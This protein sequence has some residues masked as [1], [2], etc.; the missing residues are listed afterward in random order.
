MI[1]KKEED[2]A[3]RESMVSLLISWSQGAGK[4]G[5]V[6]LE[7]LGDALQGRLKVVSTSGE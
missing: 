1:V 3:I 2:L 4:R 6:A 7:R 5:A